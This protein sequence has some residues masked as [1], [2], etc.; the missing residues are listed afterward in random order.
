[1]VTGVAGEVGRL[2]RL[3]AELD[4]RGSTAGSV[5]RY[6]PPSR[7]G[8]NGG[9]RPF[10]PEDGAPG[11]PATD[12]PDSAKSVRPREETLRQ[13]EYPTAHA[14]VPALEVVDRA[15]VDAERGGQ[16][17]LGQ[18]EPTAPGPDALPAP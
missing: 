3:T 9:E 8:T 16:L 17:S 15:L 10:R 7:N 1:V 12:R 5:V 11:S 18:A 2:E 14:P 4:V 6:P 13:R